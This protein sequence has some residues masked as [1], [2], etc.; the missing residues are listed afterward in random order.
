LNLDEIMVESKEGEPEEDDWV[1]IHGAPKPSRDVP[2]APKAPSR[3]LSELIAQVSC[4][5]WITG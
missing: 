3:Y 1:P 4:V 5:D 2:P